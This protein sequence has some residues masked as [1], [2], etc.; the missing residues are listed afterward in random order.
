M[1]PSALNVL[2]HGINSVVIAIDIVVTDR[3]FRLLHVFQPFGV[4]FLYIV[5]SVV[6]W[7]AGGVDN[8]GNPYIYPIL[9]W[10]KPEETIVVVV[11]AAVGSL[12]LHVL[13]W[14]IHL[15]RDRFLATT[16]TGPAQVRTSAYD[17]PIMD[18]EAK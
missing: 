3:P 16:K 18:P 13:L 4:L 12:I 2:V 9:D 5:F 17:N 10:N 1:T 8:E 7:A 6:Y 11:L 15:L 14:L